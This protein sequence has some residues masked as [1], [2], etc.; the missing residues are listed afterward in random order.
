[1]TVVPFLPKAEK[2]EGLT[3][4]PESHAGTFRRE[5]NLRVPQATEHVVALN[6]ASLL[7]TKADAAA[8]PGIEAAF[9]NSDDLKDGGTVPPIVHCDFTYF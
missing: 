1:M 3:L 2:H 8:Q 7:Q 6:D 4:A 9:S 5:L